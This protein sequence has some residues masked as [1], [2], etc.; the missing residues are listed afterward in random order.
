MRKS[1]K[2][3]PADELDLWTLWLQEQITGK[4]E[5]DLEKLAWV[6]LDLRQAGPKKLPMLTILQMIVMHRDDK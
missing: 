5:Y 2:Y 3:N 4:T 1:R 6:F